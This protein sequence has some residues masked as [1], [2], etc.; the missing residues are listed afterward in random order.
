MANTLYGWYA[1][2][3]SNYQ[4]VSRSKLFDIVKE[5]DEI[6]HFFTQCLRAIV[7]P[8]PTTSPSKKGDI[9][10]EITSFEQHVQLQYMSEFEEISAP[11]DELMNI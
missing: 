8:S 2:A 6:Y 1:L 4:Q 5:A 3:Q 7:L 9:P 10:D 11:I